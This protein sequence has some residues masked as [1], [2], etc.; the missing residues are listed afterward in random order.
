[1]LTGLHPNSD[2]FFSCG[3]A[4]TSK[5]VE[6]SNVDI[7]AA[8]IA[9]E[10]DIRPCSCS[11]HGVKRRV[12]EATLSSLQSKKIKG[13]HSVDCQLDST[14]GLVSESDATLGISRSKPS[15]EVT[16]RPLVEV[17]PSYPVTSSCKRV[18]A[19]EVQRVC[20]NPA[21]PVSKE[22]HSNG[23]CF[24]IMLMDIANDVK[25]VHLT[26][27]SLFH[28]FLR[29]MDLSEFKFSIAATKEVDIFIV[30]LTVSKCIE[31]WINQYLAISYLSRLHS[32][33]SVMM[34]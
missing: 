9:A 2:T 4:A 22:L 25:K 32:E 5:R 18:A 6:W 31:I 12:W 28:H 34:F 23:G 24:R 11:G 7:D 13:S 26:N 1:M 8:K 14:C 21:A 19:E 17:T 29:H 15:V 27:V 16:P 20:V 33:Y 3:D 10:T 30:I